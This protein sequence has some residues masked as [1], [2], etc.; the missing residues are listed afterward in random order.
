MA[1]QKSKNNSTGSI[2]SSNRLKKKKSDDTKLN[3]RPDNEIKPEMKFRKVK[4][5]SK[6]IK[7]IESEM[8]HIQIQMQK[9][10]NDL[11]TVLQLIETKKKI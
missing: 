11:A 8:S 2:K 4:K 9:I 5:I 7:R 1:S 10:G 3:T 6:S